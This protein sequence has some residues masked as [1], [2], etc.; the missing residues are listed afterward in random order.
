MQA[1]DEPRDDGSHD[2]DV[3]KAGGREKG[4]NE[5]RCQT[6]RG[7]PR[8]QPW[9]HLPEGAFMSA[10]TKLPAQRILGD[11]TAGAQAF[12]ERL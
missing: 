7:N 6:V 5:G 10:P 12:D 8:D 11:H 9:P 1:V 3:E 2:I 4:Q